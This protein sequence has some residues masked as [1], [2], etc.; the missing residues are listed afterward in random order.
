MAIISVYYTHAAS[1]AVI[2]LKF[3]WLK[4]TAEIKL[5]GTYVTVGVGFLFNKIPSSTLHDNQTAEI[6]VI[7][8]KKK[9][10]PKNF[11]FFLLHFEKYKLHFEM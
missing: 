2:Q 4:G 3:G 10:N 5:S 6:S 7:Y 8:P 9:K 11:L 1:I